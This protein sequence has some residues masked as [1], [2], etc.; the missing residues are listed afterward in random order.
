MSFDDF[1]CFVFYTCAKA[2][3]RMLDVQVKGTFVGR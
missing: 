2:Q 3:M 1:V